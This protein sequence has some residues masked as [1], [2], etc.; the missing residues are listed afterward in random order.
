MLGSFPLLEILK[1][2]A[3]FPTEALAWLAV[4]AIV[5]G[6]MYTAY[7]AIAQG[8][9]LKT[10]KENHLH[11]LPEIAENARETRQ[12]LADLRRELS[13]SRRDQNAHNTAVLVVLAE[14]RTA[15]EQR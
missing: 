13:D 2:L 1:A 8:R 7:Q 9:Q 4:S 6:Q 5:L 12:T 14:I 3:V 10:V 11:S 15:I